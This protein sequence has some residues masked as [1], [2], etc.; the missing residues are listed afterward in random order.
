MADN[1]QILSSVQSALAQNF[2]NEIIRTANRTSVLLRLLR[3]VQGEG[4]NVAWPIELD[5]AIAEDA[6][7]GEVVENF[8]SDDPKDA[9]LAWGFVRSNFRVGDVAA[10]AAAS[11]RSPMALANL[12]GRN[13]MNSVTKWTSTFNSKLFSSSS[14]VIGL[15][16]AIADDNTYATIDRTSG[17]YAGF[18]STVVD[19]A[20]APLSLSQIRSDISVRIY[21][22]SGF[23]PDIAVCSPEVFEKVG[24]LFQEFRRYP[25]PVTEM[26]TARGR[27]T[28]DASVGAIE[29]EGCVFFKDKDA[30]ADTLYYLNSQFVEIEYLPQVSSGML[31][32][33]EMDASAD[34]GRGALPLGLKLKKL[35]P[36]GASSDL[37][38]QG[39]VQLAVRNP[40]ACGKRVNIG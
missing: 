8:G 30:T 38:L 37:T 27:V 14:G 9:I 15:A 3:V 7:D 26:T 10:A 29:F 22:A 4:K 25:Q 36:R 32:S 13:F 20:G 31:Q 35:G 39:I 28:L 21:K 2:Y 33:P 17:T 16:T 23:T 6:T 18:R 19:S 34:D 1:P 24:T 40:Q 5:G 11:S 12:L